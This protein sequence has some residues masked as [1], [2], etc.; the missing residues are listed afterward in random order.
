METISGMYGEHGKMLT[1][2]DTR[3]GADNRLRRELS[4]LSPEVSKGVEEVEF[5][6]EGDTATPQT[7]ADGRSGERMKR[8][9]GGWRVDLGS[10]DDN[11]TA[12]LAMAVAARK[13]TIATPVF[14][15]TTEAIA[16]GEYPTADAALDALMKKLEAA[17]GKK[18]GR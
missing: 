8:V 3:F 17:G 14:A 11:E 15:E 9:G 4:F 16:R 12:V 18:V 1:A 7:T 13:A 6:V 5:K 10:D 2:A